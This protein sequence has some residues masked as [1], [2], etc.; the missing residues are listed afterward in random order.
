MPAVTHPRF[1]PS[2]F[3]CILERPRL[4]NKL[5]EHE[6]RRLIFIQG[7]AAQGKS[8]LA[9]S[10]VQQS[11]LPTAWIN[12]T[13]EDEIPVK[14]FYAVV[15]ELGSYLDQASR[16]F[17]EDYP[18]RQIGPRDP[19]PLYLDWVTTLITQVRQPLRIIFDGLDRLSED[20]Q[21][22]DFMRIL[23]EEAPVDIKF[24]LLSRVEPPFPI[25]DWKIKQQAFVLD[26]SDLAFTVDEIRLY[27]R[28]S[29]GVE[30]TKEQAQKIWYATEG[31]AG[32]I[33][34][35]SQVLQNSDS[36]TWNIKRFEEL[37]SKFKANVF[38]FFAK[39]IFSSLPEEQAWFLMHSSVFEEL[40][41]DFLDEILNISWSGQ[42]LS[43]LV[44]RNLFVSSEYESSKGWIYRYHLL[45]RDFL[46]GAWKKQVSLLQRQHF[47]RHV[48]KAYAR[49]KK[50]EQA[51]A[52]F[53]ASEDLPRA[54]SIMNAL[55]L[56]LIREGRD[57]ELADL[58]HCLPEP[59]INQK[60]WLLLYRAYCRRYTYAAENVP[61]LRKALVMFRTSRTIQ[62]Q[63]LAL[64]HLME[65]IML[66]GRDLVSVHALL[67]EGEKLL[68]SL[69]TGTYPR[70]QAFLW[71]QMGFSYALRGENT[72]DG[73]RASQNAYLLAKKLKDRPLQ[74]QSLIFSVI[75]LVF[76]GD[77]QEGERLRSKIQAMLQ[78]HKNPELEALFL[79]MWSELAMFAG[80]IDLNLVRTLI[81]QLNDRIE[82]FGLIYLQCPA[83]YSEF[84]YHMYAGNS[85]AAEEIG[86][87]LLM[88]SRTMNNDYGQGISLILQGLLAYRQKQWRLAQERIEDGLEIFR[89]PVT[90][91][92]LHDHEFS[93]GAGLIHIHLG[94]WHHAE[95]LLH[96]SLEYFTTISSHLPRTEALLSLALLHEKKGNRKS[97][98]SYLQEGFQIVGWR[99]YVHFVVLSPHDQLELCLLALEAGTQAVQ[100]S[101]RQL[102][103]ISLSETVAEE[104]H[105]ITS[106]TH[107]RARKAIEEVLRWRHRSTRPQILIQTLNG[108]QVW[109]GDTLL[110]D[111]AWDGK[112]AQNFLKAIVAL[113]T[114]HKVRKELL[115]EEL[116]PESSPKAGEKTFKAALHRLRKSLEPDMSSR[117]G[118]SYIHL[119]Y[120]IVYLDE[121]LCTT[122][123]D[124]F[125]D[126]CTQ[127]EDQLRSEKREAL[128]TFSKALALYTGDFLSQDLDADWASGKREALRQK[129]I[130]VCLKVARTYEY[131][132]S[133][134][135]ALTHY[136][137]AL[138]CD[139]ALEEA[140]RRIM[141]LYAEKGMRSKALQT[142]QKCRENLRKNLDTEPDQVTESIYRRIR[143]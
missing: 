141:V 125:H 120:G 121:Q 30:C 74:I 25:Q 13:S 97:A 59:I 132:G 38:V 12:L 83:L 130:Q 73:Y 39:E 115:I 50:L 54:A 76:T 34:L 22:M 109:L 122:D 46:Q 116:W 51:A 128:K 111:Q 139:P 86:Q 10:F 5:I 49:K 62:G 131:L 143:G 2:S 60:P 43:S 96:R 48:G 75:P 142:F 84:A 118:S 138:G 137:L 23:F 14:L 63:L 15:K 4:N 87:R 124:Q 92:P 133:W 80:R 64:G 93:I 68:A 65:A 41:S 57:H 66:L 37:P 71:L 101:A 19:R 3:P 117:F 134:T 24:I 106:H 129:Y 108:F 8:T 35:L 47:M 95:E 11:K 52:F 18:S 29:C 61:I 135:K 44:S 58:L 36:T 94:N 105:W 6:N 79:K 26:N 17:L 119:K 28:H 110:S 88:I 102:M 31:W 81:E 55:G 112:Q 82:Q 136:E 45:F 53:L 91:S 99:Q 33:V 89:R 90:R 103:R 40:E 1:S 42:V 114:G 67:D 100:D 56:K 123:V 104:E 77:F 140:Y 16:N 32:G 113:A 70:E 72:K 85:Y 20:S 9:S 127:A 21:S 78:T 107:L 126:L 7:Q 69:D 98:L 27:F